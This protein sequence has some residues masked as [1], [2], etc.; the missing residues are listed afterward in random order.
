MAP[1]PSELARLLVE[2]SLMHLRLLGSPAVPFWPCI[3][4]D[5]LLFFFFFF[6]GG[7][8][9]SFLIKSSRHKKGT[10]LVT[11]TFIRIS[12]FHC[13]SYSYSGFD[14][15]TG[16]RRKRK[17]I[18]LT[19]ILGYQ[20]I[21]SSAASSC[22]GG[23]KQGVVVGSC[24][25]KGPLGSVPPYTNSSFTGITVGGDYIVPIKDCFSIRGNI[26]IYSLRLAGVCGCS[27]IRLLLHL[28]V[29]KKVLESSL[30]IVE[31]DVRG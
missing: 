25:L 13:D 1:V 8:L 16:L 6:G 22:Q 26:P 15:V 29:Q 21:Q 27:L 10:F 12:M 9:G 24:F 19:S 30:E 17:F 3:F 4:F 11:F 20:P 31:K 14:M 28:L 18:R 5:V 7:V 2:T 23:R